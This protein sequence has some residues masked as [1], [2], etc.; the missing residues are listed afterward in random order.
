MD[1]TEI[2]LGPRGWYFGDEWPGTRCGARTRAGT[3]CKK[4]ALS[5]KKRCQLHG[6]RA[7]APCGKRNGNY[8]HGRFTKEAVR[9]QREA[10]AR[11]KALIALGRSIGMFD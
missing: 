11:I 9:E 4:A 8:K 1:E 3:P 6:G 10:K 5:G 7:G 2:T